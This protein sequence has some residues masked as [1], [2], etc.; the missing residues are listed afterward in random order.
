MTETK[1]QLTKYDKNYQQ[2]QERIAKYRPI[3]DTFFEKIAE[4]PEVCEELLRVIL[5][6]S[7][8]RVLEVNSQKSIKNLQGRSVR[9]D[10]LCVR[11]DSHFC[12]IEV[13][14]ANDENPLK[15]IRYNT[16]CIT[17]NI[18]APGEKFEMVPEVNAVYIS[19]FD[20]FKLK[21]TIYHIE[22]MITETKDVV[23]N[24]LHEVYV[25]TAIDDGSEISELMQCF[26]Q[27]D[28]DNKK[29]PKFSQRVYYFK[30]NEEGI[31]TMCS[32]S[33][34]F[35]QEGIQQAK[36]EDVLELLE[37]VGSIPEILE[38]KIRK[39]CDMEMLKRWHKLAAKVETIEEFLDN[40]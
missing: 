24:G 29:F 21:R 39:Q 26:L 14:R 35:R 19:E 38:D 18:V 6:D 3:D 10:V 5:Q 16:S 9:L 32:I 2:I 34:E 8:L 22:P 40:I 15:R 37:D 28:V 17:A 20:V 36:Q 23:D 30:H 7:E 12:N 1:E 13:H 33:E 31:K 27:T 11:G 4:E 25:N